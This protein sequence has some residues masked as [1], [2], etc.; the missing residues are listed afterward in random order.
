M[1]LGDFE[2]FYLLRLFGFSMRR[3]EFSMVSLGIS[4]SL[5]NFL[6]VLIFLRSKSFDCLDNF[7]EILIRGRPI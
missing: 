1:F 2:S 7:N 5:N 3:F 4:L 6:P